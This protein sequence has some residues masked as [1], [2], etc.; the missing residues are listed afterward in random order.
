MKSNKYGG[1]EKFMIKLMEHCPDDKYYFVFQEYPK[2]ENVVEQLNAHSAHIITIDTTTGLKAIKNIPTFIKYIRKIKPDI[3]HFHFSNSFFI[4]APIAKMMGIKKIFKTQHCC[5][6]TNDLKQATKKKQLSWKTK[7]FSWN[8]RVYKLFDKIIMCSEYIQNQFEI[9]Y[10]KSDKY[11]HIYFGV[12]PISILSKE[13][14]NELRNK[15]NID[16]N[17]T[18]I[19]TIAFADPIKGVDI[20]I[21]AIPHINYNQ[22]KVLIIGVNL[23][24]S[25]GLYIHQ[26]AENLKIMDKI[27]W[28]GITDHIDYYLSIS[29]IYCQP[30]RSEA[31]GLAV[32]E[33]KS[34]HLPVVSSNVGGL[35]EVSE[36]LFKNEDVQ[37][38]ANKL[39]FLLNNKKERERAANTSYASYINKLYM[40]NS[41]N[42]YKKL[43]HNY[44]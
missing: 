30:S 15:L 11:K 42:E 36:F 38:L 18:L 17:D 10:G 1:L 41:I 25:F 2:S 44:I 4:Y 32:C 34:A 24:T 6:T 29:D 14:Q 26:M 21:K 37:D 12:E 33:A 43:Y 28:I 27:R 7:I 40:H 22:F 20:L 9:L 16:K 8:G 23:E 31:L 5:I 13:K 3:I 19:S 35:P 39:S